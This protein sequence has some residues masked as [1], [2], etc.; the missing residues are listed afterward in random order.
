MSGGALVPIRSRVGFKRHLRAEVLP[1]EGVVLLATHGVTAVLGP[2][3]EHLA[4][5]LD[6]TRTVADVLEAASPEVPPEA[7]VTALEQLAAAGLLSGRGPAQPEK[8]QE[9]RDKS[10]SCAYWELAG[11]DGATALARLGET[12]VE[13]AVLGEVAGTEAVAALADAGLSARLAPPEDLG[14]S[15]FAVVLCEDYL[16]PD[17]G[18]VD[19]RLRRRGRPWLLA[20]PHGAEP[21][22]GPVLGRARGP[23]W[24]CLRE[25]L[26][27]HRR[28]ELA[29]WRALGEERPVGL[30]RCDLPAGR[31]IGLRLTALEA[32]KWTAGY[33]HEGQ[34]AVVT[35]DTL[36]LASR[37]HRA[38]RRPQC[39]SCG[40]P[41]LVAAAAGGPVVLCSRPKSTGGGSNHRTRAADEV[42]AD[43][44]HLVSPVTGVVAEL[45][46]DRRSPAGIECFV[47]GHNLAVARRTVAGVRDGLR[48]VSGGKGVTATEARAS[49][50]GEAIE[51][52]CAVRQG[53]EPA[54]RGSLRELGDQA[55]HPNDC[56]LFA[57]H[58]FDHRESWNRRA[59]GFQRVPAPFDPDLVTEWT[60]LWSLTHQRQRWLPTSMLYFPRDP[61]DLDPR[62]PWPDSNGN[63]AGSSLE[64]AVVQ[65]FLE[66]VERDAVA[67]WWYNRTRQPAVD[68]SSVAAP[69]L[70]ELLERYTD[71]GRRVWLLDVTT[72]LGVPAVVALSAP[73]DGTGTGVAFG[74]GAHFD[75]VLAVRRAM[76]ELGQLLPAMAAAQHAPDAADPALLTWWRDVRPPEHPYLLPSPA[77]TP[78]TMADYDYAPRDDLLDD[79]QACA[80]LAGEHGTELLV[81]EQTRPDIGLPVVK[82]VV[83][84]LRHFWARLAP[85]RLFDVPVALGRLTRPTPVDQLNPIPLFV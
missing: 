73:E 28:A 21:W 32:A 64:D 74:F 2:H 68:L 38:A 39:R 50:L 4:P 84:G 10:R 48:S 19:G 26:L 85:G 24:V 76:T 46:R 81:L 17:L 20:K 22:V 43:Y 59:S 6:G 7:A 79:V 18:A 53:D 58:Q 82:T 15:G 62:L 65:G 55:I 67:L 69:W 72:D 33:R 66:L 37:H 49:A 12:E 1:G 83:P 71:L 60:P 29:V 35:V 80:E 41:A 63:A 40:D 52:H 23:S 51:R 16:D 77:E 9:D 47:S 34:G 14:R 45:R 8:E 36:T 44:T 3:I 25:R 5:L 13:V 42:L 54:A 70:C 30:P 57:D 61:D 11:L 31:T 56:Q 75:P 78:R 27:G